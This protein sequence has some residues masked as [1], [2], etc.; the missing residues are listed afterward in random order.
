MRPGNADYVPGRR[1]P[2]GRGLLAAAAVVSLLGG[3]AS[4]G[5]LKN[6]G[7]TV[8][9][10]AA[11]STDEREGLPGGAL[12]PLLPLF[13]DTLIGLVPGTADSSTRFLGRLRD[14][15]TADTLNFFMIGDNRPGFRLSRL[16]P[17]LER[18]RQGLSLNP[19]KLVRGLVNIPWAIVN[20]LYPDFALIRETPAY[21]MHRPKW[22]REHQ[23]MSAM[24]AKI[25][26]LHARGQL[27]AA[28][29]NS[30]DLV[31]NGR[32][33]EHWQRFLRLQ[34]PLASR[35]P[36]F[37]VAGNHERT[38]TVEGVENWRTATGLPVG[39]DRLY[40]CFDSADGWVRFIALDSNPIV[41]NGSYW[42]REAQIKYSE[43]Q[44]AWLVASVKNHRGPV[45]VLMH[46]PPFSAGVHRM[47]WQRD[48]MLIRRR[49]SL[50]KAL[51][52]AGIGVI[53]AG[54]EHNYQR[55][56][57]TWSDAVLVSIVTGGAG[58]P[59]HYVPPLA[60]SARL[61]S[62]YKVAGS[63]VKPENVFTSQVFNFTHMRMWFGGGD[64][65]S[66]SVDEKS[67]ATLID[68]VEIDLKRYG[69]P[70]IDQRKIPI[71]P[72][73]GPEEKPKTVASMPERPAG[74]KVDS[75]TTSERILTKPP[76]VRPKRKAV[77]KGTRSS[78]PVAPAPTSTP[79]T[80]RP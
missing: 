26:S 64:L 67:K 18:I 27:V 41:N 62:E 28:V 25:D 46:H 9:P 29:I 76:P 58:S 37:P 3:C 20:G 63:V 80:G 60:E 45:V 21:I 12:G 48:T 1:W 52:E 30:G 8:S 44:L 16:K 42:T 75:T 38:D 49:E 71:P 55:A 19:V 69:I 53:V 15:Y 5:R 65:Y 17:Q 31:K 47:E 7:Y 51:H 73:K 57:L 23:V 11:D 79:A 33:P 6:V 22:G 78:A 34:R 14:G 35:V 61:Y 77:G 68:K 66:Y 2:A 36:Y 50:V 24:L 40:Y 74:A 59:L 54:H 4:V 56:L 10:V 70:K 43:E 32:Y 13:G 39:G 72:A